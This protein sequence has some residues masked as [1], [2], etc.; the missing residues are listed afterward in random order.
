VM[1]LPNEETTPPVTKTYFDIQTSRAVLT[2]L[3]GC[4]ADLII[5]PEFR[6]LSDQTFGSTFG[7]STTTLVSYSPDDFCTESLG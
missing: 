1:P 3:P 7:S 4:P 6:V 5:S 2:M